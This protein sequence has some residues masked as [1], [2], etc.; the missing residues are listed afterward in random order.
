MCQRGGLPEFILAAERDVRGNQA[1]LYR[2]HEAS[3]L[4]EFFGGIFREIH[5]QLLADIWHFFRLPRAL[6]TGQRL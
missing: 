3:Y 1:V 4:F 6:C 5:T 2:V